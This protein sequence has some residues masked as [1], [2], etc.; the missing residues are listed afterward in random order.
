MMVLGSVLLL[1]KFYSHGLSLVMLR[2]TQ[3]YFL[4]MLAEKAPSV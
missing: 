2:L 1:W 3:V 4:L